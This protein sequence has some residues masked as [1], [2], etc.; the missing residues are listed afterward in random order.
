MTQ[1][2]RTQWHRAVEAARADHL[3]IRVGTVE[4]MEKIRLGVIEGLPGGGVIDV[5]ELRHLLDD[6]SDQSVPRY[7]FDSELMDMMRTRKDVEK[8]LRVIHDAGLARLPWPMMT[9]EWDAIHDKGPVRRIVVLSERSEAERVEGE[10]RPHPFKARTFDLKR[11]D[12]VD[13]L[14]VSTCV[15]YLSFSDDAGPEKDFGVDWCSMPS[16]FILVSDVTREAA[17]ATAEMEVRVADQA[18]SAAV[19]LLN[20]RGI[21]K[22]IIE[23][24]E[25]LRRA[26]ARS[27][28]PAIP[29]HA[30]IRVG[31]V[32]D[33]TGHGH[34]V[35]PDAPRRTMPI[36]LRA[37]HTRVQWFGK[38][39]TQQKL[40]YIEPC[41]VNYVPG[42]EIPT[43]V[44]EKEVKW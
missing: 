6:L 23:P 30:I 28:K 25:G 24:G 5:V 22:E 29:R 1:Q 7:V 13:K 44:R 38:G 17:W 34:A 39:R 37:G 18:L 21:V 27:G 36:H 10:D 16:G 32:Y 35:D 20:T 26:R 42:A 14:C 43:V 3:A 4:V 12:G 15:H 9:V 33:K 40:V 19:L 31:H 2:I 8:S 11:Q 41:I